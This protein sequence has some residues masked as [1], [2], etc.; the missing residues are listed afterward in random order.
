ML[1]GC[2]SRGESP[3]VPVPVFSR[4]RRTHHRHLTGGQQHRQMPVGAMFLQPVGVQ[5]PPDG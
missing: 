2:R 5:V 1:N 3:A 4:C